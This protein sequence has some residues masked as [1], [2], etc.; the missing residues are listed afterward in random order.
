MGCRKYYCHFFL[1]VLVL[2]LLAVGVNASPGL[3]T[4]TITPAVVQPGGE[5]TVTIDVKVS[6]GERYYLIDETPP[7]ALS[8]EDMG[9]LIKDNQ[10]HLKIV[11]LQ[12]AADKSYTYTLKAPSA[13]G[14][15]A[16]SGI[17]Q[18]DGMEKPEQVGGATSLTVTS[19]A[20]FDFTT[21]AILSI[22]VIVLII[23]VVLIFL[24]RTGAAGTR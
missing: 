20:A 19:A 1:S 7:Q 18:M 24:K 4:R 12:D 13:E 8:I 2:C 6:A 21:I 11:K 3:M 15:Y 16:F 23:I 22:V 14:T 9:E 5:V 17:Y 10:D